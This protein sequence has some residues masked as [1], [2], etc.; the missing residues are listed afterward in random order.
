MHVKERGL[1]KPTV[2][3]TGAIAPSPSPVPTALLP[4]YARELGA[5]RARAHESAPTRIIF[6][7][8]I[9]HTSC[10]E[11]SSMYNFQDLNFRL[12]I[13]I[14]IVQLWPLDH[15]WNLPCF[16]IS[17]KSTVVLSCGSERKK[18]HGIWPSRSL[19]TIFS[20]SEFIKIKIF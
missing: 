3:R 8:C 17:V 10:H 18:V 15:K 4:C 11:V 6:L 1:Y 20:E 5:K 16:H 19:D 13:P 12:P 14:Y 2:Y 7:V 9:L